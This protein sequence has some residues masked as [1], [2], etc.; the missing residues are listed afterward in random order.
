MANKYTIGLDVG[1]SGSKAVL[2]DLDG[3]PRYSFYTDYS[4]IATSIGMA[5][6]DAIDVWGKIQALIRQLTDNVPASDIT[7]ICVSSLGEALVPVT[8]DRKIIGNSI[9][10]IDTRA[11]N[12]YR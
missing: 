11:R 12:I 7:A 1:T 5:E 6:L 3:N 8:R 2:Y 4:L 9:L 10:N